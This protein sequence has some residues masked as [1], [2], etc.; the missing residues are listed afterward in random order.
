MSEQHAQWAQWTQVLQ[1][2]RQSK[3]LQSCFSHSTLIFFHLSPHRWNSGQCP[4]FPSHIGP[5][6]SFDSFTPR[7][8]LSGAIAKESWFTLTTLL[9]ISSASHS[10]WLTLR[11]GQQPGWTELPTTLP[12][13]ISFK[14]AAIGISWFWFSRWLTEK[15]QRSA[16]TAAILLGNHQPRHHT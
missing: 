8:S 14:I 15:F 6:M 2:S 5:G 16:S 3:C 12:R 10:E 13:G 1:E 11:A 7:T 4:S 9:K